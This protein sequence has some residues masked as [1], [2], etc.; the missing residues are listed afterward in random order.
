[1]SA[2][3]PRHGGPY[4]STPHNSDPLTGLETWFNAAI[5]FRTQRSS[6]S[7]DAAQRQR[8]GMKESKG[9]KWW[10]SRA[11]LRRRYDDEV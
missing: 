10:D 4:C 2:F 9:A 1:M 8:S 11:K 5:T 3:D 7:H 6:N